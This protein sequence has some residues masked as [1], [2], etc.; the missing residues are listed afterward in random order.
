[1][2]L[3]SDYNLYRRPKYVDIKAGFEAI[4]AKSV[5]VGIIKPFEN[6]HLPL[7]P[8]FNAKNYP[9]VLVR[10]EKCSMFISL[11]QLK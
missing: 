3:G 5:S 7:P 11:V 1:V 2:T 6:F 4:K 9:A 8:S 10:Y